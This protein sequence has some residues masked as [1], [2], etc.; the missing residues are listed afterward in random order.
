MTQSVEVP[1]VGTL[2]FPDGM[3]QPDMA[4]AIQKN[5][6]Q[7]HPEKKE[8]EKAPT[9]FSG[10]YKG[11]SDVAGEMVSGM[12]KQAV[13]VPKHLAALADQP[14][15]AMLSPE[16]KAKEEKLDSQPGITEKLQDLLSTHTPISPE[17]RYLLNKLQGILSP[18]AEVGKTAYEGVE[19]VAGKPAA[20]VASDVVG[21]AGIKGAGSA[22]KAGAAISRATSTESKVQ[23]LMRDLSGGKELGKGE[24]GTAVKGAISRTQE[25]ARKE[26]AAAYED[27]D[28]AM[29]AKTV[30]RTEGSSLE[31]Q[32]LSSRVVVDPMVKKFADKLQQ[33]PAMT[34]E[35][36]KDLRTQIS[37]S[38]G[39]DRN[40]NRQLRTLRDAVTHDI[41]QAAGKLSPEAKKA[42]DTANTKW[43]AYTK[44]QDEIN[45]VLTKN[46]QGKTPTEVYQKVL[47]AAKADPE[48]IKT[49]MGQI[50]DPEVRKQFAASVLHQMSDKE[51]VFNGDKLVRE[52]G[53]MD[54]AARKAMFD[55]VGG[56]YES[57]MTNLVAKLDRIREGH[58][59]L[60]K[61]VS[62]VGVAALLS[63]LVPGGAQV[64][65]GITLIREGYKFSPATV[66]KL[67]KSPQAVK[68]LAAMTLTG[69][70]KATGAA[71]VGTQQTNRIGDLNKSP[72]PARVGD[73]Q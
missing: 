67:L 12:A 55:S 42:W 66:E 69:A 73:A 35:D 15:K 65:G 61:E 33:N 63:H 19:K 53:N 45:R 20:D 47:R 1:G 40:V 24:V 49:V 6:P 36:L 51:G 3:S 71:V 34:F 14:R 62:G 26:G 10:W 58:T 29:G 43:K 54:P 59:G 2:E 25:A 72:E 57:D 13:G 64:V 32:K 5:F 30:I 23:S 39:A 41:D 21:L 37:D 52:W 48:K 11:V 46:W 60:M 56:S 28:K 50:K 17:G 9:S 68:D 38:M 7:I 31:G 27:L 22:S 8:P 16:E 44:G 18:V 4:A 70:K